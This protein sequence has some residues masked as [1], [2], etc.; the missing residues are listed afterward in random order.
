[1][2][3]KVSALKSELA[4]ANRFSEAKSTIPILQNVLFEASGQNLTLTGTDLELAGITRVH[5]SGK[6]KWS[7]SVPVKKLIAYLGKVD[8]PEVE[9][10]TEA[11]TLTVSHGAA[12]TTISGM[13][14]ES[15]PELPTSPEA[16]ITLRGLPLA[17]KRTSFAISKEE[18]R[19][20]LNGA[21][22]EVEGD[23]GRLVATDGRRLSLAP[24]TVKG[25]PKL[26][27]LIPLAA[28]TEVARMDEDSAFAAN[29]DHT[30]FSWGQRRMIARKLVGTFPD[31][32]RVL[33]DEYPAHVMIPVTA[34]LK[35]LERVALYAD[36]RSNAVRF[37]IADGNLTISASTVEG[38]SANGTVTVQPGE[39]IPLTIGLDAH[40]VHDFLTRTDLQFCSFAYSGGK[41]MVEL[42]TGDGWRMALMPLKI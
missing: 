25:A 20:T 28:L 32:H 4:W 21:L 6:G 16:T 5:G 10:S 31:Y 2:Q 17:I 22:L 42:A 9:L 8:E 26:T 35:T 38:G 11:N 41:S 36:E 18:S 7:V 1:M 37:K 13:S 30:F 15:F 19:F 29:E 23:T 27:A 33:R 12:S 40:Y 34:T 39:G 24:I 3:V 14:K